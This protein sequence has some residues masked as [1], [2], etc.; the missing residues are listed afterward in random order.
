M[1]KDR[2][3]RKLKKPQLIR[4]GKLVFVILNNL[5]LFLPF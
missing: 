4:T 1:S 3:S 2:V 5:F